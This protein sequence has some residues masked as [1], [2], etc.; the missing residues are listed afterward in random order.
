[1]EPNPNP[2]NSTCV[3]ICGDGFNYGFVQ[4]DDGNL[5]NGDGCSSKCTIEQ[6][7]ACTPGNKYTASVCWNIQNP[8]PSIALVNSDNQI[9]IQFSKQVYLQNTLNSS[10]L[11]V[12][13]SGPSA[14]YSFDWTL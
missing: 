10:N 2:G 11:Q 6:G 8:V 9:Y 12:S 4:C 5:I 14:P 7:W 3:E 13:V 1:M